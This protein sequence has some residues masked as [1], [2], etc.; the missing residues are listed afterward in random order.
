MEKAVMLAKIQQTIQEKAKAKLSK[1]TADHSG[2]SQS[3]AFQN[4]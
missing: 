4:Y 1:T 2:E 3:K